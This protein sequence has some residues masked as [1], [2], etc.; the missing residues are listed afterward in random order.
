MSRP[1]YS[2]N[3]SNGEVPLIERD[4]RTRKDA[5]AFVHGI[6]TAARTHNYLR[7]EIGVTR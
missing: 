6:I 3:V 4:F 7:I 2:V 5:A 1:V